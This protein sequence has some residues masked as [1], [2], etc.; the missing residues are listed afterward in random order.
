MRLQL[1]SKEI[2]D[3]LTVDSDIKR[4]DDRVIHD[5]VQEVKGNGGEGGTDGGEGTDGG[6]GNG[7]SVRSDEST[8]SPARA[9]LSPFN[10]G[11]I[12]DHLMGVFREM[13]SKEELL[14]SE[15]TWFNS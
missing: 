14:K 5:A 8:G 6:G 3:R 12:K 13:F 1:L 11:K 9:Q 2:E 10:F 4:Q 7:D 15:P